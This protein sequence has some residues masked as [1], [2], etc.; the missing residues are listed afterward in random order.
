MATKLAGI[1]LPTARVGPT[2]LTSVATR[3]AVREPRPIPGVSDQSA[4]K[5]C[6]TRPLTVH[7]AHVND[8]GPVTLIRNSE[9]WREVS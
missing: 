8:D 9:V 1:A 7:I 2:S 3:L 4:T 5:R 6:P